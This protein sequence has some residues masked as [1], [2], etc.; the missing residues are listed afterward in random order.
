MNRRRAGFTLVEI[1]AAMTII[2]VLAG[3]VI[4]KTGDFIKRAKAAAIVADIDV[5]HNALAVYYADS[6]AYPPTAAVGQVPPGLQSYLPLNFPFVRTDYQ[7]Q[8]ARWTLTSSLGAYPATTTIVAVTVRTDDA[9]L[10]QLVTGLLST[11][12]HFQSGDSYTF[13]ID[14]M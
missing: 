12:P 10:G 14:G 5:I 11:S 1:L 3:I 8:Y 6:T 7:L 13:I 2:A 4:P 9:R